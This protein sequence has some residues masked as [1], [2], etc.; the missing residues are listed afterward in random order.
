MINKT[1]R[2]LTMK[3]LEHAVKRNFGGL[4]N[5]EV[6]AVKIF[7]DKIHIADVP[8]DLEDPAVSDIHSC[9]D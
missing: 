6:D 3:Q 4:D 2:P 9:L 5:N 7:K 8:S 1:D